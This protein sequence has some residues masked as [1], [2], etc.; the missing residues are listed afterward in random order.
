M[1]KTYPNN[2]HQQYMKYVLGAKR[3]CT[4]TAINGEL[5]EMPLFI[6]GLISLL[7][8]WHRTI[9]LPDD[10]LVKQSLTIIMNDNSIKSEWLA[11]VQYILKFINMDY[12]Y[13]NPVS[14]K[15][16]DFTDKCKKELTNKFILDWRKD[17]TELHRQNGG[18]NKLRFY[19]LIKNEFRREPYLDIIK[20]FKL[21]KT[22]TKFRC[23][24]H[25]L[26]IEKGRHRNL[27]VEDRMCKLCLNGVETELHFLQICP[28]YDNLRT[29]YFA[30]PTDVDWVAILQYEDCNT[31]FN[32]ANFI[33]KALKLRD[34]LLN[35]N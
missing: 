30:N 19:K 10:T 16:N 35:Q 32:I 1:S 21:R 29:R 8:F 13:H 34:R 24:D 17:I 33:E 3:N 5:G 11:T 14:I 31:L 26:E 23:S 2:M 9:N 7:S 18:Q 12:Y 22:M 28:Y 4:N 6:H 20:S 15:L 25:Q 27:N